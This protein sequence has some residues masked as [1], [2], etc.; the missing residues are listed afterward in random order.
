VWLEATVVVVLALPFVLWS[1]QFFGRSS[2]MA[3]QWNWMKGENEVATYFWF[4]N[5]GLWLFLPALTLYF[6]WQRRSPTIFLLGWALF[7][8]VLFSNVKMAPWYWDN[9]KLLVWGYLLIAY[10]IRYTVFEDLKPYWQWAILWACFF[11]GAVSLISAY[12]GL[13]KPLDVFDAVAVNTAAEA[14]KGR[15][16]DAVYAA[17]PEHNHPLVFW[18]RATSLGFPGHV[19]SHGYDYGPTE[20]SLEELFQKGAVRDN[21]PLAWDF[22]YLG[23]RE[24]DHFH[25]V[26]PG[27]GP[28]ADG[29]PD[30]GE[31]VFESEDTKLFRRI[32][33][34]RVDSSAHGC[35][36]PYLISAEGL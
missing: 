2:V 11:S 18:G 25:L 4:R 33:G 14:I 17:A 6:M 27:A 29:V 3:L 12:E 22:L 10:F 13:L 9:I 19:W 1:T 8:F 5:F 35:D 7:L 16:A 34:G 28:G 31:L 36:T 24:K 30:Y 23:P 15:P 20:K 26:K 32:A 21:A